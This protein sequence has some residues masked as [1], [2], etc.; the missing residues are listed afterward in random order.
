M[1]DV[2]AT[3]IHVV[4]TRMNVRKKRLKVFLITV[5]FQF[6]RT[7]IICARDIYKS[8][9]EKSVKVEENAFKSPTNKMVSRFQSMKRRVSPS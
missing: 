2:H 3:A 7:K 4:A 1:S 9:A 8:V 5:L 6:S